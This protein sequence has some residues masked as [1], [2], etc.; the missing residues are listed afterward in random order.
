VKVDG[1]TVEFAMPGI[2]GDP[3]FSGKLADDAKTIA[4]DFSQGGNRFPFRLERKPK[5][6]PRP[7]DA[8]PAHGV[9]GKGLAGK[10]RGALSPM[11]NIQLRLELEL[12]AGADGKVGGV[13]VSLDQG[14]ARIPLTTL[15]E[16][17][18][19]VRFETPSVQ[20]SFTGK[21]S[22]DG[23]EIAGDWT[24]AGR[25]TPLVLKRLSSPASK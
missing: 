24:Q 16:T 25:T 3:S 5:P 7:E 11:P 19:N 6:A 18:G 20:G 4:G 13:L 22:A 1:A 17:E 9:P 2:P 12:A 8:M 15:T 10:W 23:S 21:L 14:A